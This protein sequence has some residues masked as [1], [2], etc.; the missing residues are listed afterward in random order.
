MRHVI[1]EG[2]DGAG[3]TTL[4]R[5]LCHRFGLGYHHE[6]P[7]PPEVNALHHYAALLTN[8]TRPTVFDR[9]HLG[10]LVYGELLRG[11]PGLSASELQ[12]MNR[13][14]R[15]NGISVIAALPSWNTCLYN[16]R[17]KEELIKDE[18]LLE[19]AWNTWLTVFNVHTT[20]LTAFDYQRASLEHFTLV[21]FARLPDGVIGSPSAEILLV[22]EQPNSA[23]LDLPFFGSKRSSGWLNDRIANANISEQHLALTNALD[24]RGQARDLAFIIS[25]MPCLKTVIT[26]GRTAKAQVERQHCPAF[27]NYVEVPHPQYWKRFRAGETMQYTDMLGR[28]YVSR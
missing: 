14:I 9:L 11:G 1:I 16:T 25:Q 13:L 10:E 20:N 6:G 18:S 3:K 21:K 24:I 4:A 19:R 23:L 5:H 17:R 15:G 27:V 8:A 28:A 7:P 12:L 22:G 26:L 2:P